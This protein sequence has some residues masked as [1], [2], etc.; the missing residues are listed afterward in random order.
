MLRAAIEHAYEG[1]SVVDKDLNLVAWNY[2]YVELYDYPED[3]LQPGMSISEVIRFNASRGYCGPG[4]VNE[5]V[6]RRV[7]HM[8]NGTAHSSERRR[9]DAR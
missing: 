2:R 3:F 9:R 6:E 1:M 7:Q 5:H 8:R 4:D